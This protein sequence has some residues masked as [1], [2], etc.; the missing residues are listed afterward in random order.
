MYNNPYNIA[1]IDHMTHVELVVI[2]GT[3]Y[4][5]ISTWF[6]HYELFLLLR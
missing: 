3:T 5:I 1:I 2:N 6:C 4:K